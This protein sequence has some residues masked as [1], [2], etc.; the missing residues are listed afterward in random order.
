ME[1]NEKMDV[2]IA[3]FETKKR[4]KRKLNSESEN[5]A[6]ALVGQFMPTQLRASEKSFE[7]CYDKAYRLY[8]AGKYKEALP[9][10]QLLMSG[11]I[12]NAKYS[13]AVAACYHMMQN[14]KM[15]SELYT[16]VAML[17][18]NTPL[19]FYYSA[20]CF[21]K[22]HDPCGALIILD[23]GVKRGRDPK[24]E[25]IVERMRSMSDKLEHEINEKIAQGSKSFI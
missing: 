18:P 10:F 15:A 12:D 22:M 8:N 4:K 3:R 24:Y 20:D 5:A 13:F 11:D 14:Y 9:L 6:L 23:I 2:N 16:R 1:S 25:K 7:I 17:D 19:P 21:M